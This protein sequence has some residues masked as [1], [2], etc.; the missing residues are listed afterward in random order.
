[1][2]AVSR[3]LPFEVGQ[4]LWSRWATPVASVRSVWIRQ[5]IHTTKEIEHAMHEA[6]TAASTSNPTHVERSVRATIC[7]S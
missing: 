6:A 2:L 1:M 3:Y 4:V 5:A 7:C